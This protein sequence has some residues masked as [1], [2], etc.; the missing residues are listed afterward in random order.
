MGIVVGR[1]EFQTS[2]QIKKF[3][4][5]ESHVTENEMK[6]NDMTAADVV[7][8]VIYYNIFRTKI[9]LTDNKLRKKGVCYK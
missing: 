3:I 4:R 6:S 8:C 5:N 2:M 7:H 9:W 1:I